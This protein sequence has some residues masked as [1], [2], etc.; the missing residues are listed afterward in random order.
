MAV[1]KLNVCCV[2]ISPRCGK[3]RACFIIFLGGLSR[4]KML[5]VAAK[6]MLVCN[7][8]PIITAQIKTQPQIIIEILG[9]NVFLWWLLPLPPS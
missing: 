1:V 9:K 5:C 8:F 3:I 6:Y 7:T 2:R 4:L